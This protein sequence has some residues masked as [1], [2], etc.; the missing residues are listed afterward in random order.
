MARAP[1]SVWPGRLV[2]AAVA[3]LALVWLPWQAWS[4]SGI[5]RL[6][7]LHRELG[8]LRAE[9][10][11]LRAANARLRAEVVLHDEEPAAAIEHAAREELGLV[12]PGEVVF[13]LEE[14]PTTTSPARGSR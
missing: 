7:K 8:S 2:A 12:K 10:A 6:W 14:A 1:R 9:C 5:G 13:K 3:A 4:R 11:A